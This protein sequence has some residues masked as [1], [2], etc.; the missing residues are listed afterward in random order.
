M[1]PRPTKISFRSI[2]ADPKEIEKRVSRAFALLFEEVFKDEK[3][4]A[5]FFPTGDV[6]KMSSQKAIKV[7]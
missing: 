4:K 5:V 7:V 3:Q 6:N 1:D 2:E